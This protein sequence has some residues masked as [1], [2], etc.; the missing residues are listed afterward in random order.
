MT[1]FEK[2]YGV[3]KAIVGPT[4]CMWSQKQRLKTILPYLIEE[5]Y[6]VVE[7]IDREDKPWIQEEL[8]DLLFVC[9]FLLYLANRDFGIEVN[10]VIEDICTKVK[11]RHPHVFAGVKVSSLEEIAQNWEK[12]KAEEKK[13]RKHVSTGVPR[14]L[15]ALLR[16]SKIFDKLRLN[17]LPFFEQ[18]QAE[19]EHLDEEAMA[20]QVL[21]IAYAAHRKGIDLEGAVRRAGSKHLEK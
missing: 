18:R 19:F 5:S 11:R 7:A 17:S 9:F 20:E 13:H 14:Q 10:C 1:G 8:G 6:E 15:G 3:I 12:I 16:L 21:H 2:L 4:G